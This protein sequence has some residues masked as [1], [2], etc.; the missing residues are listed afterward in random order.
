MSNRKFMKHVGN[1]RVMDYR[2]GLFTRNP[3]TFVMCAEDGTVAGE[4]LQHSNEALEKSLERSNSDI[5]E[6]K[7]DIVTQE[8]RAERAEK[9]SQDLQVELAGFKSIYAESNDKVADLELE[10]A[11]L[12][13]LIAGKPAKS[14]KKKK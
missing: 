9:Q 10:V 4:K 3:D 2:E 1:E 8:Q 7:R 12:K 13:S 14:S 5:L 6:L 11:E